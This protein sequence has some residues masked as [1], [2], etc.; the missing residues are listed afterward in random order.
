MFI[1]THYNH[2]HL[3]FKTHILRLSTVQISYL[4]KH[5]Y[6]HNHSRWR[7]LGHYCYNTAHHMTP[8]Q[9]NPNVTLSADGNG[10]RE[11]YSRNDPV[12]R[13]ESPSR[14][15]CCGSQWLRAVI[16]GGWRQ[17]ERDMRE[18]GRGCRKRKRGRRGSSQTTLKQLVLPL[19]QTWCAHVILWALCDVQFSQ[20]NKNTSNLTN[21]WCIM[22]ETNILEDTVNVIY[23]FWHSD[24]WPGI[25]VKCWSHSTC[26]IHFERHSGIFVLKIK[27]QQHESRVIK[28]RSGPIRTN[29]SPSF[30]LWSCVA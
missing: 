25:P 30:D 14:P 17:E 21:T 10:W 2:W 12:K 26:S 13:E 7:P 15:F 6:T 20:K 9:Q 3:T 24:I 29:E 18:R 4:L 22:T 19:R 1:L 5:C 16:P 27:R 11:H 28:P 8:S 23:L